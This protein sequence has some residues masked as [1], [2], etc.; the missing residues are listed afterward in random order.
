MASSALRVAPP[1]GLAVIAG[2]LA[3]VPATIAAGVL[4]ALSSATTAPE[5]HPVPDV[6]PAFLAAY[7]AS[8][9]QFDL[10]ADGW[11]YLAAIGKI[12]S[13]HGRSPAP[14]VRS[15][16]NFHGCC[17]GPMQIHNGFGSGGGTWGRFKTDG[18][19]DGR[20]DVYDP[21]DAIA[22]AARYLRAS[23]APADWRRAV[24]AYNHSTAYVEVVLRQAQTYRL[25]AAAPAAQGIPLDGG[26]AWLADVPGFLGERCDQRI[27]PDVVLLTR[28]YGLTLTDCFG[29]APHDTRGEHP[30][31]LAADLVPSDGDWNRTLALARA[32]G[33]SP[34]CASSG[35]AGRGPFRVVLYNGFPGHGDPAHSRTPHL[36]LSWQHSPAPPFTRAREVLV[37]TATGGAP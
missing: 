17:A 34:G 11:S 28:S 2:V 8:A 1:S 7:E 32:A 36:H 24:F 22:T 33:W 37:L 20:L 35:C 14:G 12:E 25:A 27:V 31:G 3:L 13:D 23:G 29:G 26:D 6:P 16:Q 4:G 21:E 30:L 9:A 5:A 18:D 10:G 19:E 15:G